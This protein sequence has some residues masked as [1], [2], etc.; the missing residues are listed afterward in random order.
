LVATGKQYRKSIIIAAHSEIA[1]LDNFEPLCN[2]V[3]YKS[4]SNLITIVSC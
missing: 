3:Q 2:K 1:P 4:P